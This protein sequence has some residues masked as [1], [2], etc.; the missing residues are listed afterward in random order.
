MVFETLRDLL[1]E[2]LGC[3]EGEI[4][5]RAELHDDLGLS[6]AELQEV[7]DAMGAELGFRYDD[8]ELAECRTVA[9]L[10]RYVSGLI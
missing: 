4:T 1:A 3:D 2:A 7:M 6:D 8:S 5:P 10:V 9:Q